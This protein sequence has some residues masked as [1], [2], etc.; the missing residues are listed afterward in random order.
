MFAVFGLSIL[1]AHMAFH[2]SLASF[3]SFETP[4]VCWRYPPSARLFPAAP[5]EMGFGYLAFEKIQVTF[6]IMLARPTASTN[7]DLP[8][9]FTLRNKNNNHGPV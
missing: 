5:A 9:V 6:R 4:P 2:L 3:H 8:T 1:T 7:A